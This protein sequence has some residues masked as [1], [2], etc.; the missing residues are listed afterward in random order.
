M[1]LQDFG[2][3]GELAWGFFDQNG[4]HANSLDAGDKY[5]FDT[6][7]NT[8]YTCEFANGTLVLE[9]AIVTINDDVARLQSSDFLLG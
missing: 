5:F 1:T 4:L 2:S 8:L 9:E 7:S 3:D 6:A